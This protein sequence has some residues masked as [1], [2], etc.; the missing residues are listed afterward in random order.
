M[1][2]DCNK[3]QNEVFKGTPQLRCINK[4]ADQ[5]LEIVN[6]PIC[7]ACPV[8]EMKGKVKKCKQTLIPIPAVKQKSMVNRED[9]GYPQCPF[10]FE[11]NKNLYCSITELPVTPEICHRCDKETRE[12]EAD[13]DLLGRLA[14][15][16]DYLGAIRRWVASGS[17]RR[18]EEEM[19]KIFNEHCGNGCGRYDPEKHACKNCG[20]GVSTGSSALKNKLVMKTEHC[21][22][23]RF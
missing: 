14:S 23:G 3:R 9:E 2:S 11:G 16:P 17:P 18:T 19:E 22:L 15:T 7:E 8:R 21:P 1:N 6:L 13:F 10:R 12:R 20:C 4:K 5:Y